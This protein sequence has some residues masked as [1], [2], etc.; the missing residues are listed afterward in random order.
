MKKV[1]F[2]VLVSLSLYANAQYKDTVRLT[3]PVAEKM[4]LEKNYYLLAQKFDIEIAE[5]SIKQAKLWYNPTFFF[6]SNFYN[7]ETHRVFNYGNNPPGSYNNGQ[8][9]A[10]IT[11]IIGL[12]GRRSK[13][14]RQAQIN[15][16]LEQ[17]AFEDLMR[18]LR[19][20]LYGNYTDLYAAISKKELLLTEEK[21]L[22]TLVE[23]TKIEMRQGVVSGYELTRLQ[24]ELQNIQASLYDLN[25]QITDYQQTLKLLL[26]LE[27]SDFVYPSEMPKTNEITLP[28]LEICFDSAL[29]KRPDRLISELNVKYNESGLKVERAAAVP[30]LTLGATYDRFGN[31]YPGYT[32]LN[33]AMDIPVFNRNQGNIK[34]AQVMVDKSK[35]DYS[36]NEQVIKQEVVSA[37]KKILDVNDLS[38]D[39]QPNYRESLQD[40]SSE[41]TKNYNRQL[42][43]LLDY[44]D[45]I[46][47]YKNARLN[48]IDLEK[49]Y[50]QTR[51]YFNYVTNSK[52][53]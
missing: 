38:T 1:L 27:P 28:M 12:A 15:K 53:F 16:N 47:T 11:Q 9:A 21:N 35:L 39:I 17:M 6:E 22:N 52:F 33:I 42:I 30:N 2:F 25:N 43:S 13:L 4:F 40:I 10:Q 23:I 24:F 20:E 18:V 31:A 41:A 48:L 36:Y 49:N 46:R 5:T 37:Y 50:F 8:F 34:M 44:L 14:V 26:H 7:S 19:L 32:G 3:L 45:K 51:Q 29:L